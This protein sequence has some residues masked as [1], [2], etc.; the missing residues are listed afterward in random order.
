VTSY[1]SVCLPVC[2]LVCLLVSQAALSVDRHDAET[3]HERTLLSLHQD[4]KGLDIDFQ[5]ACVQHDEWLTSTQ[6]EQKTM[7]LKLREMHEKIQFASR[8]TSE[9]DQALATAMA[10]R[11]TEQ[12]RVAHMERQLEEEKKANAAQR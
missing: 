4:S 11:Q 1:S 7:Q 5:Q 10:K 8:E 9:L 12:E 3:A 6:E 2:L